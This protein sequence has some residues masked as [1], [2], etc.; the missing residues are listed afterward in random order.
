MGLCFAW[1]FLDQTHTHQRINSCLQAPMSFNRNETNQ[2]D[3]KYGTAIV[4]PP[5]SKFRHGP[6]INFN[7]I[8]S[9][10]ASSSLVRLFPMPEKD[11]EHAGQRR[12]IAHRRGGADCFRCYDWSGFRR[13]CRYRALQRLPDYP[14]MRSSRSNYLRYGSAVHILTGD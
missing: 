7:T 14:Q 2:T 10:S 4:P 5:R 1:G 8:L 12:R 11:I 9:P 3:Q 13:E 6:P